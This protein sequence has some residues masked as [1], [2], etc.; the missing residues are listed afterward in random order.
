MSPSSQRG[1]MHASLV[2]AAALLVGT[3]VIVEGAGKSTATGPRERGKGDLPQCPVLDCTD[4]SEA[5]INKR[6]LEVSKARSVLVLTGLDRFW[7]HEHWSKMNTM[8]IMTQ[9][10]ERWKYPVESHDRSS[11]GNSLSRGAHLH[12]HEQTFLALRTGSKRWYFAKDPV[13]TST[14]RVPED[15]LIEKET[16]DCTTVQYANEVIFVPHWA[17]HATYNGDE[18]TVGVSSFDQSDEPSLEIPLL[19]WLKGGGPYQIPLEELLKPAMS[20]YSHGDL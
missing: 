15:E 7:R 10:P 19:G 1:S 3:C 17:W 18:P 16:I 20:Q 8:D 11:D 9:G 14:H 5:D 12:N 2:V 4:L 6:L 13:V